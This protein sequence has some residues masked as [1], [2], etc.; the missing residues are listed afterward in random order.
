VSCTFQTATVR[1]AIAVDTSSIE[2]E[3]SNEDKKVAASAAGSSASLTAQPAVGWLSRN[4]INQE[5][6]HQNEEMR[7]EV[8]QGLE[9]SC[10]E[11][12]DDV[13]MEG[14][15]CT[16]L[17]KVETAPDISHD[18]PE[19][20]AF[21]VL[22]FL[23]N[24]S[25]GE[26][27]AV[28]HTYLS[29]V[30]AYDRFSIEQANAAALAAQFAEAAALSQED[31][32]EPEENQELELEPEVNP[33]D[34]DAPAAPADADADEEELESEEEIELDPWARARIEEIRSRLTGLEDEPGA[35]AEQEMYF[36]HME[37]AE[38]MQDEE[39]ATE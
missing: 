4:V 7:R 35:Q 34:L 16:T 36:L 17:L 18:V 15:D 29:L 6:S 37:M 20:V 10:E 23:D 2:E 9:L 31:V 3:E 12:D 28:N 39:G 25:L 13:F 22:S 5:K 14:P 19:S 8:D 21:N 32:P 33:M 26:A 1:P 30:S 38:I 27:A 24:T 11:E